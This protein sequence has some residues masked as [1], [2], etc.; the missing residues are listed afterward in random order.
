MN[1][2]IT[3]KTL[4]VGT[5]MSSMRSIAV[6][7]LAAVLG[8]EPNMGLAILFTTSLASHFDLSNRRFAGHFNSKSETKKKKHEH[9]CKFGPIV[10]A[11]R[12]VCA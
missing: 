2:K 9:E 8:P 4:N 11:C 10:C 3:N 7:R 12:Q 1:I 6:N 5:V